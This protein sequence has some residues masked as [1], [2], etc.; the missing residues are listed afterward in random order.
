MDIWWSCFKLWASK[1]SPLI[2]D[3]PFW[4]VVVVLMLLFSE[5][6]QLQL[7]LNMGGPDRVSRVEMAETVADIRGYN[8][9][10]I[11]AVSA[12]SVS[13]P[14]KIPFAVFIHYFLYGNEQYL[15]FLSYS[16]S[17]FWLI[18]SIK[19]PPNLPHFSYCFLG[20]N[21]RLR[22]ISSLWFTLLNLALG[23]YISFLSEFRWTGD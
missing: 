2:I 8:N 22:I 18:I 16:I 23:N 19:L 12:S 9:S 15:P 20:L 10:L 6:K 21:D 17:K 3:F 1:F 4:F 5:G 14:F 13:I 7:L 11:K